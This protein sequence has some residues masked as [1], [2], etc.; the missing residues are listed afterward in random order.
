[1]QSIPLPGGEGRWA[2]N[3][4]AQKKD[5]LFGKVLENLV[6][7]GGQFAPAIGLPGIAMTALPVVAPTCTLAA[8]VFFAI[9][10]DFAK[11]PVFRRLKI[12]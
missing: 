8:A 12:A 9:I 3:L 10:V 6:K 7:E 5:S 1:M 4:E 2:L 11:V